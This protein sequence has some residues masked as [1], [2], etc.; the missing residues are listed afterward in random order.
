MLLIARL[1]IKQRLLLSF[2]LS[3]AFMLGIA[4]VGLDGMRKSN[5]ALDTVNQ[6]RLI[7]SVQIAEMLRHVNA[8]RMLAFTALQYDPHNPQSALMPQP[9]SS[10]RPQVERNIEA[11]TRV[12]DAYL[13]TYLT[14][15]EQRLADQVMLERRAFLQEGVNPVFEA[16]ER[17]QFDQAIQLYYQQLD[18]IFLRYR[19][20]ID[21]LLKLQ[22]DVAAEEYRQ[23]ESNFSSNLK[24][25]IGMLV[26]A[27]A[28]SGLIAMA[29]VSTIMRAVD[30]LETASA[31]LADGDL[32]AAV[33]YQGRDELGRVAAAFNAMRLRMHEMI[34]QVAN[35]TGQ[36]AAASEETTAVTVQTSDGIRRQQSETE[37]VA[38]AMN[39]MSAT[40]QDVARN[41]ASAAEAAHAADA[42]AANGRKVLARTVEVINMLAREVE[43]ATG[44][45]RSL[46][47]D[48]N[49]IGSVLDVIRAIAEQTNL[50]ALNA[51]IEAARAGEAGRGFAVVADEV[52]T[53][54]SRTQQSTSEIQAMI[55][56]LQGGAAN[57]VKVMETG[58]RQAGEGVTQVAE[59]GAAL[60]SILQAVTT[61]NDMNA[62]IASAAEQQS[63]VAEEIN[64]NI[65][66]VSEIAEQ[67]SVGSQQTAAT[68]EELAQLAAQLQSLVGQFRV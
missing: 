63:A 18:P 57:A 31:R 35:A 23:A 17:G 15:E 12:I 7:P 28:A 27:L 1:S 56:K 65:V 16:V 49:N 19:E 51:A 9:L 61:I 37:Q 34:T 38:A 5:Q 52:R 45:I 40:V 22:V 39:E 62:Q 67:T 11:L 48:S 64:R 21:A 3:A 55:E 20:G 42:D 29:T 8:N 13:A 53:L 2:V 50:L 68:S 44:V 4:L 46:Q 54:A 60:E 36:L 30:S 41:A 10:L 43:N 6:D 33:D 26:L 47:D 58:H 24:M 66:T 59:A 32:L 25:V 14:A